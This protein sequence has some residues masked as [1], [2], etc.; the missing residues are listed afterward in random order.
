MNCY[1]CKLIP[2]LIEQNSPRIIKEFESSFLIS[3]DHQTFE[4]YCVLVH[5]KHVKELTDLSIDEN[6][7]YYAELMASVTAI[8]KGFAHDKINISNYGN[9]TPHQHWHIFPRNKDDIN[10]PQPPW[11][12]LEKFDFNKI[13]K[14]DALHIRDTLLKYL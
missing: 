5:K 14:E 8:Q 10:W 9:V 4:G 11:K 6:S 1:F 3:G 12:I 2:E 7:L 13:T